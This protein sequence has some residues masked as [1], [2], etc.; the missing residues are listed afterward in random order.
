MAASAALHATTDIRCPDASSMHGEAPPKGYLRQCLL[1]NGQAHGP[2]Q[3]WYG[4]GQLMQ[5]QHFKLGKE[6][7]QQRSWWPNGQLMSRGE[8]INGKRYRAFEYWDIS[9]KAKTIQVKTITEEFKAH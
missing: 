4:N 3:Q 6:H 2:S 9:G 7:G 8:S 1:D 5:Q